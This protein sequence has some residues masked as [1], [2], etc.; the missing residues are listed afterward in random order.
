M[1]VSFV[2]D[3]WEAI[4][5]VALAITVFAEKVARVTATKK[6]D[7]WVGIVH[8]ALEWLALRAV[9]APKP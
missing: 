7:Y 6:D 1:D 2:T 9:P 4:V 3:N 8:T 5:V